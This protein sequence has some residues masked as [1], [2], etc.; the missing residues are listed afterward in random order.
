MV[1]VLANDVAIEKTFKFCQSGSCCSTG[2]LKFSESREHLSPLFKYSNS[3]QEKLRCKQ[4]NYT[5]AFELGDCGKF[6]FDLNRV[7]SIIMTH[8][9]LH[10]KL[11]DEQFNV[12]F[13]D[14]YG[15]TGCGVFKRWV[16]G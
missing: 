16:Q 9:T 10:G 5:K 14:R 8:I 13:V 6:N 7:E 3:E 4:N 2:V 1:L 11:Y 15:N 12:S